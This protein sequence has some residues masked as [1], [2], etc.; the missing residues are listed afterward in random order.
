MLNRLH[1]KRMNTSSRKGYGIVCVG[2]VGFLALSGCGGAFDAT[3][4]GVVT[5][6]GNAV[7]RGNVAFYPTSG[8]PAAYAL[9]TE[10][11]RYVVQTGRENGL[12]SGDYQVSVT[13][14]ELPA[15]E[16]GDRGGPPPPGKAITP[17]WYA[18]KET[19]GL[20]V[21]VKPGRNDIPLELKAAPPTAQKPRGK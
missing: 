18:S 8:G 3:A 15:R 6:D 9:I 4:S 5:L 13:A 11:G 14:N 10:N 7:P 20:T 1:A 19:S 17:V 12:P 16:R 21:T 2:L